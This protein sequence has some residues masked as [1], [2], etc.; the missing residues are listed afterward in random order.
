MI[1]ALGALNL[2]DHTDLAGTR[3]DLG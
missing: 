2:H 3:V 1:D